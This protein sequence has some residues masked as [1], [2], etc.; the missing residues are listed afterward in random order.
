MNLRTLTLLMTVLILMFSV[1]ANAQLPLPVYDTTSGMST[2]ITADVNHDGKPDL[3]GIGSSGSTFVVT[4]LL[5]NGTG[6]FPTVKTSTITGLNNLC[7]ACASSLTVGDFNND[8]FPD[9]VVKGT[10]PVTGAYAVGVMLG[11]GDGTFKATNVIDIPTANT[12]PVTG[13]FNNDGKIDIA[14]G[15]SQITVLPGNGNGTFGSPITTNQSFGGCLAAADLNN[16]GKLDLSIGTAVVLGNGNGTFQAPISVTNGA[17]PQA[18]VDVNH[19]GIPDLV[20]IVGQFPP[21]VTLW[22]H[23]GDG[24]GHFTS[25]SA[26]TPPDMV[27]TVIATA[28]FNS[29]GFPD[30]AVLNS[31]TDITI[32]LNDSTGKFKTVPV[33]FNGGTFDLIAGDFN[34]DGKQD[35]VISGGTEKGTNNIGFSTLLG[36]GN[37]TF[38][39]NLAENYTIGGSGFLAAD[40]NNDG[41]ADLVTGSD[42]VLGSGSGTFQTPIPIASSCLGNN[43]LG[44]GFLSIA[45]ADFNHD[46]NID[47]VGV[48]NSDGVYGINVCFGNGNGTFQA[49]T[50]YDAN[51]QHQLILTGD[52]NND[53]NLDLAVSD[54]SGIS[55]LL[56]NSNGTFQSAI[57]TAVSGSSFPVFVLGDFTG[58]GKLDIATVVS[59]NLLI[60]PGNGDGTFGTPITTPVSRGSTV[61]AAGDLNKDG[62][63]DLVMYVGQSSNSLE[64]FLGNGNGT[65]G[66]PTTYTQGLTSVVLADFLKN[67]NLD[68][69]GSA[70]PG[71]YI[72]VYLNNGNGTFQ[73]PLMLAHDNG[74]ANIAVADINGD[75]FLDIVA[76]TSGGSPP[77]TKL[78][79]YINP[80]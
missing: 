63:L 46:H 6:A 41:K 32:L 16:D 73:T 80:R 78:V 5:N 69:A 65:F 62:K 1:S 2:A 51:I 77:S 10:D 53:G 47:V 23:I 24:T 33:N 74:S 21:H 38:K 79:D 49:A 36:S 75:G 68:I 55:V 56:G 22:V 66:S 29:D 40:V 37:G 26:Y 58:D 64:V 44:S 27:N 35:L 11:N 28:D 54:Q 12:P 70:G 59:N 8:G 48:V 14:V 42:V 25:G 60:L 13:D 76:L 71:P 72:G 15:G 18:I 17:C 7:V 4:V 61:E 19:D 43:P 31:V 30:L 45:T 57:A 39:D 3:I 34:G 9:A 67:G 52:F 50:T 20:T